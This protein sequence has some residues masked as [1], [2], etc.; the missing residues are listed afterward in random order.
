MPAFLFTDIE[1]ST[2][3][4]EVHP[5]EMRQALA[6]HDDILQQAIESNEG[7]VVKS[8]GDGVLA[9]FASVTDSLAASLHGQLALGRETWEATGP[10]Q[11][12]MGIHTGD[13]ETRDGDYFGPVLNRTAR[14]MAAGHGGQVLISGAAANTL[15]GLPHG[16]TLLDLGEHRL[17]DLTLPEHLFQLQHPDLRSGFPPLATLD[18]RPNN[19]PFQVSEF[20][21]RGSEL[22]AIQGMLDDPVS[23]LITLT[24]PGGSGK[25]RLALQVAADLVDHYAD[26]VFFVDVS[27][28]RHPQEVFETTVRALDLSRELDGEPL[29]TLKSALR[30]REMLMVLDNL[31]QV[32]DA[33]PGIAELLQSCPGLEIIVTSREALRV[34]A[35]HVFPVPPL[36]LPEPGAAFPEVAES[37]A[38]QLFVER[39]RAV[40]PDFA[41]TAA[42]APAV[43][44]ICARLDGLPLAIELAA[45]RLNVFSAGEL[46]DRL[47]TRLDVLGG[48]GRDLPERQRTLLGTIE[49]SYDLLDPEE[50]KAFELMSVFSSARLNGVE[51]VAEELGHRDALG[52]LASLVD[53]SLVRSEDS[54]G[55]RRFVMLRTV[56]DYAESRLAA[57][58]EAESAARDAHA[59]HYTAVAQELRSDL[60]GP[61]R[62]KA[63]GDLEAESGNLRSAW[64]H[65]VEIRDLENLYLLLDGL[66]ALLDAKGWYHTAIELARDLLGLLATEEHS[67]EVAAEELTLRTS[68]ARALMAVYGYG[69]EVEQEFQRTVTAMA[70]TQSSPAQ[71][72]PVLRALASYYMNITEFETSAEM[73]RRLLD[74]A[75]EEDDPTIEIEGLFITGASVAFMGDLQTGLSLL[76]RAIELFDP[77]MHGSGRYRLGTSPGVTTRVASAL[78]RW[79]QGD[80]ELS[81]THIKQALD[82]ARDLGHPFSL[83]YALYHSGFA[84][85]ARYDFDAA[86]E[87]ALDLAVVAEQDDY[88]VWMALAN[89]LEGVAMVG[90]GQTAEG[91]EKTETG[92][93]L[94]QGLTTPPVFWP[95]ILGLRAFAFAANGK[96]DRA[97]ALIDEA[98]ALTESGDRKANA[99][100]DF[101]VYRGDILGL[102]P[103]PDNVAIEKAY[104]TA[105]T[106]AREGGLRLLELQAATRLVILLRSLG[107]ATD[108]SDELAAVY[109][110]FPE[111]VQELDLIRAGQVLAA[112][113]AVDRDET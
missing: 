100:P 110:T 75:A 22:T 21:G 84:A 70:E 90:L 28:E 43:V 17:K 55:A 104:R 60:N 57:T 66:W 37:E 4:W 91:L 97:L 69:V 12:R 73:G 71:R 52:L 19:L 86:R 20:F 18:A 27:N 35:E 45:A 42:N 94:Y 44:G 77:K 41:L 58:P 10:I 23:R 108:A 72:F 88:R 59:R 16:A 9:T 56:R 31:E 67:A 54:A 25:T 40:L 3:L 26:G 1:S 51:E 50:Q 13:A 33:A 11:V 49:W 38:V 78:L 64:R 76:D 46:L 96:H 8:L 82:L 81:K 85:F 95:L 6:R 53:K 93:D 68:L 109:S 79:Q 39:A 5:E 107:R 89:V 99:S 74:L 34:R 113:P 103:E 24:G 7:R 102:F 92:V 14:I 98:I 30:S 106:M 15:N 62:E 83:A 36:S 48:G 29:Q 105:M 87:C 65:W 111:G 2:R 101:H 112:P 32:T 80:L 63:L 47:G 61:Q